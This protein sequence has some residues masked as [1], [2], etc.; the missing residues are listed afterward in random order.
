MNDFKIFAFADEAGSKIDEQIVA[1]KKNGLQG[2]EIRN[3]D[4]TN[5]SDIS[6]DKAKEVRKKLDDAGF[7]TWSIGSPIGKIDIEKDD[8]SAHTDKLKHTLEIAKV[9][10]TENIRMFS[11][12]I[13]DGKNPADYK[14]EVIERLSIFCDI[15]KPYN[16]SL[17][18]ENEKGIYGDIAERC[19]ILHKEIPE[20]KG[21]F[22]PA[23]YVQSGEDTAKAW[24]MLK[25]YI[26]YLHI[27]DARSD[28]FVVP[29]GEGIGNVKKIVSE[30]VS[31]GGRFFTIEPHLTVF[32]GL[33]ALEK[34]GQK[35]QID[36]F[37]YPNE[38]VAFDI[39]CDM[40]KKCLFDK[41]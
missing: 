6:I 26:Y 17:C 4:G 15:A 30:Y 2:L 16:I 8:F 31:M 3:V 10:G 14:N 20:L 34:E 35:T 24:E 33:E 25:Q 19:L 21:V 39:A 40:F 12:F 22:D 7:I 32:N 29:A 13:P 1:M 36:E 41:N 28:G 18:H 37:R 11:F 27:K 5:V 23:N 9:L 38:I